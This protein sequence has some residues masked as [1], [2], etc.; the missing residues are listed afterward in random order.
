VKDTAIYALTNEAGKTGR[1]I[2]DRLEADL[3]L[4]RDYAATHGAIP[5]DRILRLVEKQFHRYSKH[6]F[7]TAAGV[8]IR[9]IAPH[10]RSKTRD[11]AVVVLDQAGAYCISLLSGHLGGA[12][13]LAERVARVTGG[14]AVITTATDS[15]GLISLDLV[16]LEKGMSISNM[17]ALKDVNSAVLN[18]DYL[19]VFD[20]RDYLG[21]REC[22]PEGVRIRNLKSRDAWT[23]GMVGVWV[24]WHHKDPEK[25]ML[26]LH[27]GCIVAGIGCNRG[28]KAGEIVQLVRETFRENGLSIRS[29]KALGTIDAKANEKGLVRASEIL[30]VPLMFFDGREISAIEVPHPSETVMRRMGVQSV[31]EAT[32]ILGTGKGTLIVPKTKGRNSTIALALEP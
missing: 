18:G 24:D 20:P 16:A 17:E 22:P 6:I 2:A 10:I 31:C 19:H 21:F 13:K 11:P 28:T 26:L 15:E 5:F 12:N 25:G 3:Y 32:A 7:I 8:A 1:L 30:G 14:K 27:P 23:Q 4:P 29:L 9:A